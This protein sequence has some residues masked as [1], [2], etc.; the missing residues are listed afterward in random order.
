MSLWPRAVQFIA[1]GSTEHTYQDCPDSDCPRFPCRV[2]REGYRR[3]YDD[4]YAAGQAAGYSEGYAA[5][6]AAGARAGS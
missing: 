5:G 2:Y 6:L 4:G 3:G 1:T